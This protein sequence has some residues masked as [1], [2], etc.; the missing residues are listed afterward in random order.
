MMYF[1]TLPYLPYRYVFLPSSRE[2]THH[3]C[4]DDTDDCE[5]WFAFI[6]EFF[7]SYPLW[8][9]QKP[10]PFIPVLDADFEV[11]FKKDSLWAAEDIEAVFDQDGDTCKAEA[12]IISVINTD[13]GKTV[14]VKG[15]VMR[16][17]KPVVEVV[18]VFFYCGHYSDYHNT[19]ELIEEPD[20]EVELA[21]EAAV[22][23]F[24]IEGM[25][26]LGR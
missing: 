16:D 9:G 7:K 6:E 13:A 20:Y 14:K 21:T 2:A 25:V 22:G 12:R 3:G 19:F 4:G 5:K 1:Y 17:S 15:F 8:P 18:S 11:W 26:R 24:A 23:V 10:V